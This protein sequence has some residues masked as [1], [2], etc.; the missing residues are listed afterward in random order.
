MAAVDSKRLKEARAKNAVIFADLN[1]LFN[2][3]ALDEGGIQGQ[4]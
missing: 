3:G 4:V 1:K 2:G